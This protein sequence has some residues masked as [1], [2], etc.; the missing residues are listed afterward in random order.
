LV[1]DG[2]RPSLAASFI[3]ALGHGED[4]G[5][6]PI[7]PYSDNPRLRLKYL[8]NKQAKLLEVGEA[9]L[10]GCWPPSYR[11]REIRR[12]KM[13]RAFWL[14]ELVVIGSRLPGFD[15]RTLSREDQ[16]DV[17][18]VLRLFGDIILFERL[19]YEISG[20]EMLKRLRR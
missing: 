9:Y 4:D 2:L 19:R 11:G 10:T 16:E 5:Y 12:E 3:R 20:R 15:F 6:S 18:E 14:T 8:Q 17:L 1:R 7:P 13:A